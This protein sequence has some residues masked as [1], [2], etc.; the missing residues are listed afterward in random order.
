MR[1]FLIVILIE[2]LIFRNVSSQCTSTPSRAISHQK[3]SSIMGDFTAVMVEEEQFGSAVTGIGDLDGDSFVDIVVTV[4]NDEDG[5]FDAGAFY[6]LFLN[7]LGNTISHQKV[8][9]EVGDFTG[10]LT[11]VNNFQ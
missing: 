6:V 5:G 9:A 10:S 11:R 7:E 1:V 2:F 3:I 8:S 4:P